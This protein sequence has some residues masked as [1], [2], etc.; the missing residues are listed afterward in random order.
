[1]NMAVEDS[2]EGL[3]NLPLLAYA[4]IVKI[5]LIIVFP[6]PKKHSC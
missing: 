2:S 1:M 3:F 5:F 4:K 6:F